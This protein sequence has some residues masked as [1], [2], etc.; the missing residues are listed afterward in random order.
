MLTVTLYFNTFLHFFLW[1]AD[2]IGQVVACDDLDCFDKNGKS[3]KKKP[4]TLLD[5]E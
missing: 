3:G 5:V 4:I 1:S 2:V